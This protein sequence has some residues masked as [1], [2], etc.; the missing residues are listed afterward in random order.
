MGNGGGRKVKFIVSM[1]F[2]EEEEVKIK[3]VKM[4]LAF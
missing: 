2:S 1:M 4:K 3:K